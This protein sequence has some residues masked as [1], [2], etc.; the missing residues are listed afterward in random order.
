MDPLFHKIQPLKTK[1]IT[2]S[3]L[4]ELTRIKR[5]INVNEY[6]NDLEHFCSIPINVRICKS[7]SK[8]NFE[9]E[10][11]NCSKTF[12]EK[13]NVKMDAIKPVVTLLPN[14]EYSFDSN[15]VKIIDERN[16]NF[17]TEIKSNDDIID[18]TDDVNIESINLEDD[19]IVVPNTVEDPLV[20]TIED[21]ISL[22]QLHSP[23]NINP[24]KKLINENIHKQET[25]HNN[26]VIEILDITNDNSLLSEKNVKKSVSRQSV[27]LKLKFSNI[28][29]QN[30]NNSSKYDHMFKSTVKHTC[31]KKKRNK[32]KN[33]KKLR[34]ASLEMLAN[35]VIKKVLNKQLHINAESQLNEKCNCRVKTDTC[36]TP[37]KNKFIN[38]FHVKQNTPRLSLSFDNF[39][40]NMCSIQRINRIGLREIVI[41][42]SNVAIGH[43]NNRFFSVKGLQIAIEYFVKKGHKVT[44]FVPQYRK[45][46]KE[47][48]DC[49]LLNKLAD[50]G[51]VVFTPSREVNGR[52]ITPYDDR[53]IIQYAAA[54]EGIVVSS[55]NY[56]DLLTEKPEWRQTIEKRLLMPTWVGDVLMFP[57][58]PLG[59]N[60]PSLD[61]FLRF[62]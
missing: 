19:V 51:Y 11:L 15:D 7:P 3:R 24:N 48:S 45:K 8:N 40:N 42:G 46:Y 18:I 59:R 37:F 4:K 20:I 62:P 22:G 1:R 52:R 54:C 41:D 58:D 28:K 33:K 38:P 44:A 50:K 14:V 55:D 29:K 13:R 9:M 12:L 56:R 39:Q 31:K 27:N 10:L 57:Q 5:V 26:S 34:Q 17:S 23:R 49:K 16:N 32:W 30:K 36:C 2:R 60:G 47:T 43:S 35:N 53:Y 25:D 6:K 61:C 21:A